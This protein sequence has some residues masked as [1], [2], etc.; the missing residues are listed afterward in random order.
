MIPVTSLYNILTV[1]TLS[2]L[3]C[4][5]GKQGLTPS[6]TPCCLQNSF[7][8]FSGF[9][10]YVGLNHI[11]PLHSAGQLTQGYICTLNE[12]KKKHLPHQLVY[13]TDIAFYLNQ[14]SPTDAFCVDIKSAFVTTAVVSHTLHIP[15]PSWAHHPGQ[16]PLSLLPLQ[17]FI[18][19]SQSS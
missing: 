9:I 1:T 19:Q 12:H 15:R 13:S 18:G 3:T 7:V 11:H 8:S 17:G 2:V 4:Y 14:K 16:S 5:K 6:Q 10:L